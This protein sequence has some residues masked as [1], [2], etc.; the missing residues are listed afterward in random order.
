MKKILYISLAALLVIALSACVKKET[1]PSGSFALDTAE[2]SMTASGV[3]EPDAPGAEP[4]APSE[5]ASSGSIIAESSNTVSDKEIEAILDDLSGELDSALSGA[6]NL[7][8]LDNT[9]L[10]VNDIE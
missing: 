5:Q 2:A 7:E 1:G 8:D 3:P 10:D 4:D 9:D 6:E